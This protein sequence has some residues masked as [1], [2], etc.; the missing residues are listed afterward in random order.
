MDGGF[1]SK[2][3][4]EAAKALGVQDVCF[5]KK[6]GLKVSEMTRS[7]WVYKRPPNFRAG[8]EGL[9]SFPKRAVGLDRCTWRGAESVRQLR[10]SL[11]AHGRS[12]H[13]G[14]PPPGLK[15]TFSAVLAPSHRPGWGRCVHTPSDQTAKP[16]SQSESPC[17]AEQGPPKVLVSRGSGP[18]TSPKSLFPDGN[19]L[20]ESVS[21]IRTPG[22]RVV[23]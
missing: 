10:A 11:G 16:F 23:L 22:P 5:Q 17:P 9:I 12:A 13:P 6:R 8:I 7:S 4:L 2:D 18:H 14:P 15:L 20:V 21:T 19:E 1:A 3:N